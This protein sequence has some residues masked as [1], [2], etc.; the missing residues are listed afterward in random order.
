MKTSTKNVLKLLFI[1]S[2]SFIVISSCKKNDSIENTGTPIFDNSLM[3][4]ATFLGQVFHE[5]GMPLEEAKVSINGYESQTDINGFFF[6]TA[7]N[8]PK[9]ATL[10]KVSKVGYFDGY[11]TVK[12]IS[13]EDNHVR[14]IL[15]QLPQPMQFEASVGGV[16]AIE[17]GGSVEFSANAIKELHS[18]KVYNGIVNVYAK[19][20]N[21]D[22][23]RIN[24]LMP[25]ALRAID[26]NNRERGLVTFGMQNVE[27]Y[28]DQGQELQLIEGKNAALH[29]PI[30][31]NLMSSAPKTIPLWY[32]DEVKGMW[33]EEGSA[34]KVGNEYVGNV[35]HFTP[36]NVDRSFAV[37][38]FECEMIDKNGTTLSNVAV[39]VRTLEYGSFFLGY[40]N[41]NGKIRGTIPSNVKCELFHFQKDCGAFGIHFMVKTFFSNLNKTNI[42]KVLIKDSVI[43]GTVIGAVVDCNNQFVPNAPVKIRLY[44]NYYAL[45]DKDGRFTST[46]PCYYGNHVA[47]TTAYNSSNNEYGFSGFTYKPDFINNTGVVS[48]CGNVVNNNDFVSLAINE[49]SSKKPLI[50]HV[51]A[52]NGMLDQK[53]ENNLTVI[54]CNSNDQLIDGK[55]LSMEF[56]FAGPRSAG[57]HTFTYYKDSKDSIGNFQHT[58]F[59]NDYYQDV[60]QKISGSFIIKSLFS[61]YTVACKY[62]I[63]RKE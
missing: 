29:F 15:M 18:D 16:V 57:P 52:N 42:G 50:I 17:G 39:G 53:W 58:Y 12:V 8:T 11:R 45:T 41:A 28:G 10:I 13:N 47:L 56:A 44:Q 27:L 33:I 31:A 61:N 60:G 24:E 1:V 46:I 7:I 34:E 2:F 23:E 25:G 22:D 55:P 4:Q 6:F 54:T 51:T 9:N 32:F 30:S 21:P 19:W 43:F 48:N 38:D 14:I 40:A 26:A 36:W 62:R 3:T 49:S 59:Y 5:N 20:I 35:G 37:S 63:T